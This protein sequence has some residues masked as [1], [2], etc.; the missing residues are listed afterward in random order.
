MQKKVNEFTS[1]QDTKSIKNGVP[2]LSLVRQ[3]EKGPAEDNFFSHPQG[4]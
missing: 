1:L 2:G 3:K 4:L